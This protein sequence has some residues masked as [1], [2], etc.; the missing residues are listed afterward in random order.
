M[1][2]LEN[3]IKKTLIAEYIRQCFVFTKVN[4]I[5]NKEKISKKLKTF[6][7]TSSLLLRID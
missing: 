6:L 1:M 7:K 3:D 2:S 5:E 4:T